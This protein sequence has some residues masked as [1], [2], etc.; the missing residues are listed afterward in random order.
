MVDPAEDGGLGLDPATGA[1]MVGH[2]D[3]GYLIA[4]VYTK[5]A[6]R[7]ARWTTRRLSVRI[8]APPAAAMDEL[9][10]ANHAPRHAN[11]RLPNWQELLPSEAFDQTWPSQWPHRSSS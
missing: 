9:R 3:G 5:L 6:R 7:R 4:T 11:A 2:D 10:A 8:D 1:E